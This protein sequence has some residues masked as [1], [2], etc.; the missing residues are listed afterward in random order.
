M[1]AHFPRPEFDDI[2]V[3]VS[4]VG[5]ATIAVVGEREDLRFVPV[6]SQA[7]DRVVEV[8]VVNVHG[9][10]EVQA[11]AALRDPDLRSPKPIRVCAPAI[12]QTRLPSSRRA[13]TGSPSASA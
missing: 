11:A 6:T 13:T 7:V 4:D 5:G 8:S 1:A 12:S 10:M 3:R 9:V 2:T